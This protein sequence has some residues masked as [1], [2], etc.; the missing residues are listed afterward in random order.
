MQD[1]EQN[2]DI[3]DSNN[4]TKLGQAFQNSNR[5]ILIGELVLLN[6]E[7]YDNIGM[8]EVR[9]HFIIVWSHKLES[10]YLRRVA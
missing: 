2:A 5:V 9:I 7:I 6:K 3:K 4:T 8:T 10:L 1:I